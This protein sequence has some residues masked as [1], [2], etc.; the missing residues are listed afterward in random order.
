MEVNIDRVSKQFQEN[1]FQNQ[2]Y[3]IFNT[4]EK[5]DGK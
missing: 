5:G 1:L 4:K 2:I 3:S